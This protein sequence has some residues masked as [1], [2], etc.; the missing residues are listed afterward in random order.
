MGKH[1]NYSAIGMTDREKKVFKKKYRP[2]WLFF[3]LVILT[4]C[5]ACYASYL[6]IDIFVVPEAKAQ[7]VEMSDL[8]VHQDWENQTIEFCKKKLKA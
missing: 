7:E 3:V 2:D 5:G 4:I 1:T 8:E 6:A